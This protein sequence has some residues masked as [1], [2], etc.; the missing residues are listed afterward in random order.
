[1]KNILN[2]K[3][4]KNINWDI[5]KKL[6]DVG[7]PH[8]ETFIINNQVIL[9]SPTTLRYLQYTLDIL[10]YMKKIEMSDIDVIEVGGGYG[11]QAILIY[12]FSKIFSINVNSYTIVDLYE[13]NNMQNQYVLACKEYISNKINNF[14]TINYLNID[15]STFKPNMNSFFISNY[16]LGELTKEIQNFYIE[17]IIKKIRHGYICWNFS[18]GNSTIHPYIL[19][20]PHSIEDENPQTNCPPVK[21]YIIKI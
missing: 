2:Y 6:N 20:K 1:L 9:L 14:N 10:S 8:M 5:V 19:N 13:A 18:V 11:F 16:A 4:S 7:S 3:E 21:S 15:Q 17:N 12:E